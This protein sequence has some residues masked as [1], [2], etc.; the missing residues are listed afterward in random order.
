MRAD[1]VTLDASGS[2]LAAARRMAESSRFV[3]PVSDEQSGLIGMLTARGI[4]I[5]VAEGRDLEATITADLAEPC[6]ALRAED[7]VEVAASMFL[8]HGG[9][10]LPVTEDGKVVG[11]V[12]RRALE[13]YEAA[14]AT[15]GGSDP[16]ASFVHDISGADEMLEAS[17]A[18]Y[19]LVGAEGLERIREA[20]VLAGRQT[21]T[22]VL[23]FGCGHGRVMR[24]L[25][26]AFPEARLTACDLDPDAVDYCASQFGATPVH[27]SED[28]GAIELDGEFDLI[29]AGSLF[30]H[31]DSGPWQEFLSLFDSL[32]A[33]GGVLVF[34][35]HGRRSAEMIRTGT[36]YGL[37]STALQGL[38][39]DYERSGF[40]YRN[41]AHS[42]SYGISLSAPPWVVSQIVS[43]PALRLLMLKEAG[44][45]D[46][47]D[48]VGCMRQPE[49]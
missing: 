31:V 11:I 25:K 46:H 30:T 40:A 6:Q 48:V 8:R 47:Q 5:A 42:D 24:M 36:T 18:D 13:S 37:D 32:L 44:W 20:L 39:A 27:S 35:A 2:V 3:L 21:V 16:G 33:P 45:A 15:L 49:R 7:S 10:E 23:D 1:V 22:N 43:H 34:S 41:Y 12:R 19:Y 29:W 9:S 4:A 17:A 14:Q 28:I 26:A 38:V